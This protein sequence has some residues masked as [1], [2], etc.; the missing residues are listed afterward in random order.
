MQQGGK[1]DRAGSAGE[2]DGG[3]DGGERGE[4]DPPRPSDG[5]GQQALSAEARTEPGGA[6]RNRGVI[7]GYRATVDLAALDRRVQALI[8]PQ[9]R[10]LSREVIE[11]IKSYVAGLPEV[12]TVYVV[13]GGD[14]LVAH[15]AAQDVDQLHALLTNRFSP[16]REVVTFRSS[17]IY[18]HEST[19]VVAP[20]S[21]GPR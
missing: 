3:R 15:V 14:D 9:I 11:S 21:R 8:F 6:L 4:T 12:L 10:P 17:I 13:A 7:T 19:P 20:L 18:Q 16:R 2:S 1:G 5:A